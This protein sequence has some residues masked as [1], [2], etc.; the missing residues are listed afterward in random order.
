MCA[1]IVDISTIQC[2]FYC[3]HGAKYSAHPSGYAIWTVVTAT[4]CGIAAPHIQASIFKGKHQRYYSR[5]I[6]N[7]M[8]LILQTRCQYNAQPPDYAM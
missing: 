2:A 8:R 1:A 3:K 5:Y 7:S 4:N 6:D